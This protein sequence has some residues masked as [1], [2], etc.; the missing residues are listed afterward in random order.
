MDTSNKNDPVE[1]FRRNYERNRRL[2][3]QRRNELIRM[4]EQDC[5]LQGEPLSI[6]SLV[7]EGIECSRPPQAI[8]DKTALFASQI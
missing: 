5:R 8:D 7:S 4:L 2:A 6:K 1:E 3:M